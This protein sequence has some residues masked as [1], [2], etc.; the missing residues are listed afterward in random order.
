MLS[1]LKFSLEGDCLF[2]SLKIVDAILRKTVCLRKEFH[3]EQV[4]VRAQNF[5]CTRERFGP[6]F[7]PNLCSRAFVVRARWIIRLTQARLISS[8]ASLRCCLVTTLHSMIN[9]YIFFWSSTSTT[10]CEF[11]SILIQKH[12]MQ[13]KVMVERSQQASE[14][15]LQAALRLEKIG[16]S[17]VFLSKKTT[18]AYL[19][20][21]T[22]FIKAR[23]MICFIYMYEK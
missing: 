17:T 14:T 8:W 18:Y 4:L 9:V 20:F 11:C 6:E 10:R 5:Q 21:S 19:N 3:D 13:H 12:T 16:Q 23:S 22:F 1:L 2:L 15:S 7:C